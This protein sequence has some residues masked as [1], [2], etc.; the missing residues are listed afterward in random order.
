[1]LAP[2]PAPCWHRSPPM[3]RAALVLALLAATALAAPVEPQPF[4]SATARLIEAMDFTGTPL[5][6]G[7]KAALTSGLATQDAAAVE[8]AQAV[9]DAHA[10]FVVSISPEQRGKVAQG[11]AKPVLDEGGWRQFLV[12]V[13][14]DAGTTARLA[15]RSA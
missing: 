10:L 15:G 2:L 8:Q 14:N 3:I 11:A 5:S 7:E 12:K 6:A 4:L 1:M 13:I 9:L